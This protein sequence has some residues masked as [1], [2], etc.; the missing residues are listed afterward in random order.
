MPIPGESKKVS[1]AG[2]ENLGI[3]SE[4][5]G[6]LMVVGWSEARHGYN[7][8]GQQGGFAWKGTFPMTQHGLVGCK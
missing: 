1:K 6:G 4:H 7:I 8:L 2:K 5:P 3:A